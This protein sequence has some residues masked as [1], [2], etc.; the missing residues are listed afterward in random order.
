MSRVGGSFNYDDDDIYNNDGD[1]DFYNNDVDD[2]GYF[3][4]DVGDIFNDGDI[5]LK[6][7]HRFKQTFTLT[8]PYDD[9]NF[10]EV[11]LIWCY[12]QRY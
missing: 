5:C 4:N 1:D 9:D 10:D 11:E 2:D 12:S 7:C 6:L 3:N 8:K